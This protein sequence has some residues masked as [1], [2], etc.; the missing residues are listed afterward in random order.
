MNEKNGANLGFENQLWAA[1]KKN[2][3]TF[4]HISVKISTWKRFKKELLERKIN[5]EQIIGAIHNT[6]YR[7]PGLPAKLQT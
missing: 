5:E 3:F 2:F 6:Y 4:L 7:T 1:P